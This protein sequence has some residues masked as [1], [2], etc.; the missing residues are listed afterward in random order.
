M[1][2]LEVLSLH[3]ASGKEYAIMFGHSLY[4]YMW[5]T[6]CM[7]VIHLIYIKLDPVWIWLSVLAPYA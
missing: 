7:L 3:A 4:I 5:H 6:W 2:K 1:A